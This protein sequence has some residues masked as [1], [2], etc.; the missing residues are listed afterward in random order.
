M[1]GIPSPIFYHL[2][3]KDMPKKKNP[4]RFLIY[5][6][7]LAALII[8]G[9]KMYWDSLSGPVDPQDTQQVLYEVKEGAAVSEIAQDLES[10]GIIK[11]ALAFKQTYNTKFRGTNIQAGQFKLSKS[12]SVEEIIKAMSHSVDDKKVTI[13]EGLRNAEVAIKLNRELGMD[14]Q[15]FMTAA[16]QGYMFPDTYSFSSKSTPESIVQILRNNFDRKFDQTLQSKIRSKGLS[17]EQGIILAS[18][19]ER[20]ARSQQVRTMVASILLKRWK[21][22]M[23]LNADATVQY[24]KDTVGYQKTGDNYKFWQPI[25][26]EEYKSVVSPYNTYL[27]AG[28]PPTPICNPSL[29]S[30]QAVA[31]AD[32]TTPYLYYYHDSQG[33]SYYGKTLE[34]H[35]KNVALH[36]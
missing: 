19:V 8:F 2:Q 14:K 25:T 22:G 4:F 21:M 5:F 10:Q 30:I 18:L 36:R 32:P 1:M 35:N 6:L 15:Q 26:V 3:S 24:A 23:A 17:L 11:S 34:E 13:L 29:S 28:F 16:Q 9:A 33:S 20:E 27:H 12:M 31:D 7:I